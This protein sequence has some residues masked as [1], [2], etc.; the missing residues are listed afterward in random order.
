VLRSIKSMQ[1]HTIKTP[2]NDHLGTLQDFYFDDHDWIIRYLV[3]ET[4][5]SSRLVLISPEAIAASNPADENLTTNLTTSQ[6]QASPDID[7][8]SSI[9]PQQEAEL[10]SHYGWSTLDAPRGALLTGYSLLAPSSV[11]EERDEPIPLEGTEEDNHLQE[12]RRVL[13]YAVQARDGAAGQVEDFLIDDE[14]WT[15]QYVVVDTGSWLSGRKV[16]VS[17]S[18]VYQIDWAEAVVHVDLNQ[19]TVKNSPE[20][21]LE[22]STS[23]EFEERVYDPQDQN[24]AWLRH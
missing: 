5:P 17:P 1:G 3:V 7:M 4:A 11:L 6:I 15:L 13:K 24:K 20:Y 21:D 9:T 8:K 12:A 22:S 2:N 18:Y 16:L 19:E 10:R 14:S 23:Q